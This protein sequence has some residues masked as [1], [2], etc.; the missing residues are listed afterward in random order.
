MT[1]WKCYQCPRY[2]RSSACPSQGASAMADLA[3]VFLTIAFF[4]LVVLIA[5]GVAK[6]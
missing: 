2:G 1:A 6:L 3:F 5:K 4:A